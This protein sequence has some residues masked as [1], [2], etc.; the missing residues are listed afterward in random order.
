MYIQAEVFVLAYTE[1]ILAEEEAKLMGALK[2]VEKQQG[3]AVS[4]WS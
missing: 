2:S 3:V 4:V 1:E